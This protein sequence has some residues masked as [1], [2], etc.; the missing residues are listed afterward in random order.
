MG[1]PAT[2]HR[3][4]LKLSRAEKTERYVLS[5]DDVKENDFMTNQSL[6]QDQKGLNFL[7]N[8]ISLNQLLQHFK[9]AS[10][11]NVTLRNHFKIFLSHNI[12]DSV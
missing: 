7:H 2:C 3:L 10:E 9:H 1:I 8:V 6:P 5:N 11:V 4:V 12:L